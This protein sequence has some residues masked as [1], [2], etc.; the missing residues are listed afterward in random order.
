MKTI[1]ASSTI[2]RAYY[3]RFNA[4]NCDNPKGHTSPYEQRFW[5]GKR[6]LHGNWN[7]L[8]SGIQSGSE[9]SWLRE[10]EL[11][12]V[13]Y[14]RVVLRQRVQEPWRSKG[15]FFSL[16]S[17]FNTKTF[18]SWK[19]TVLK[20]TEI[21]EYEKVWGKILPSFHCARFKRQSTP[22]LTHKTIRICFEQKW[23]TW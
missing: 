17:Y 9:H 10:Q 1:P 4:T 13:H 18:F 22:L 12:A 19:S 2:I 14:S 8:G 21:K 20:I 23:K 15:S 3:L 6:R 5:W 16:L 7:I 11:D